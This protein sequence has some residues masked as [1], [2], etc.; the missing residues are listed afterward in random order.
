MHITGL[1]AVCLRPGCASNRR[2][3]SL[4]IACQNM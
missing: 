2:R 4:R 1:Q 3:A